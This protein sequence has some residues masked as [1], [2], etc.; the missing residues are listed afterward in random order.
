M[1]SGDDIGLMTDGVIP[2]RVWKNRSKSCRFLGSE[3]GGRLPIIMHRGSLD[4]KDPFAPLDHIQVEFEDS[5]LWES[6]L[7]PS[8]N[9]G[10]SHLS[11]QTLFRGEVEISCELLGDGASTSLELP[12]LQVF[13]DG[14][15]DS[16]VIKSLMGPEFVIFPD[17]NSLHKIRG[18]A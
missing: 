13:L 15:L 18:N 7:D 16:L 2:L 17:Q 10:L 12:H 5:L 8:R 4:S 3:P 14:L 6:P 11:Q 1:G 9:E